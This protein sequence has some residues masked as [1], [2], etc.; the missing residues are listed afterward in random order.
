MCI[1]LKSK[2]KQVSDILT[3]YEDHEIER[4]L[5]TGIRYNTLVYDI[6]DEVGQWCDCETEQQCKYFIQMLNTEKGI[7]LGDFI[8]SILKITTIAKE[9][10]NVCEQLGEI[11][12]L[13]KLTKIESMILKYITTAQSLY[14]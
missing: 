4:G 5:Q 12:L 13:H 8:K 3:E 10:I 6:V 14:V 2:I 9:F 7:S 1:F 11:E